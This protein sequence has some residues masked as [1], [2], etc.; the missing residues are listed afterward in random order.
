MKCNP[1][2]EDIGLPE[3]QRILKLLQ[4]VAITLE[5]EIQADLN[6][7]ETQACGKCAICFMTGEYCSEC[8]HGDDGCPVESY[9]QIE[10]A[11]SILKED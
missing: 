8:S 2:N 5:S 7:V 4:T 9:K 6:E 1:K 10:A 11:I 3:D